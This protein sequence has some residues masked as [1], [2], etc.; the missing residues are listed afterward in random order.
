MYNILQ[1]KNEP[2]KYSLHS[3]QNLPFPR[4]QERI[5]MWGGIPISS[6]NDNFA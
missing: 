5:D 4:F 6:S 2:H 1:I 3:L